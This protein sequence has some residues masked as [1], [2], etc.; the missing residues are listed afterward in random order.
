[1]PFLYDWFSYARKQANIGKISPDFPDWSKFLVRENSLSPAHHHG[2]DHTSYSRKS[3]STPVTRN[4]IQ[5]K[6][7]ALS[8]D[9]R[10]GYHD[11]LH[12]NVL[13]VIMHFGRYRYLGK[14]DGAAAL[15][16]AT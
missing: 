2:A 9:P 14:T 11:W 12:S 16:N 8:S 7:S 3:L 1:L 4:R 15:Q 10:D 6:S 13:D 5:A